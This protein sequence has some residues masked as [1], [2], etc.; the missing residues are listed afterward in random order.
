MS[1]EYHEQIQKFFPS[2]DYRGFFI[3]VGSS[4][5]IENNNTYLL[6]ISG[7]EGIC[8]EPNERYCLMSSGVRKNVFQ[9]AC[10]KENQNDVEFTIFGISGIRQEGAISSLNVDQRLVESHKDLINYEQITKVKLRTLDRII[11]KYEKKNGK[12][13]RI[14]FIS[15]DTEN[16]E[17]DVLKGFDIRK[18]YPK[19][20]IIENNFDEN[21]I[22][23]YLINFGYTKIKRYSVNDFYIRIF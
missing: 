12:I 21:F 5:P 15:I 8:I 1:F 16:T 14:D 3:D 23:E 4:D 13:E 18:W 17:L 2:D 6:E 10:G 9:Y 20:M 19:L 22:E 11:Q 7:W